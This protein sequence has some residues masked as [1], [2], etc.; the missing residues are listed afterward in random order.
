VIRI[1][2][3]QRNESSTQEF[4][5]LQNQGLLRL[6]LRGHLVLCDEA[7]EESN[8]AIGAHAFSDDVLIPPGMYVLLFTGRG[9]PRWSRTRDGALVYYAFMNRDSAVWDRW[10]GPVHILSPQHSF[11]ERPPALMLRS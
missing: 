7:I 5:L 11:T 2:G 10:S 9:T 6:S 3:L 4:V 1:V 8:L